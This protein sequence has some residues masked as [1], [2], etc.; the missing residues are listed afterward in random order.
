MRRARRKVIH[1]LGVADPTLGE[2]E[3]T[4]ENCISEN[5]LYQGI[6]G[7]VAINLAV[8]RFTNVSCPGAS[9]MFFARGRAEDSVSGRTR[10]TA[11]SGNE[12]L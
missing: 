12:T 4:E 11:G 1:C 9:G 7:E 2:I 5:A 8:D 3:S 6:G 10:T